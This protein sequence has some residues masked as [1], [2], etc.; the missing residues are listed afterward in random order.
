MN[1]SNNTLDLNRPVYLARRDLLLERALALF[2]EGLKAPPGRKRLEQLEGVLARLHSALESALMAAHSKRAEPR[3]ELLIAY[4]QLV[5]GYLQA[6]W[7]VLEYESQLD[8]PRGPLWKFMRR[9]DQVAPPGSARSGEA[10]LQDIARL[11]RLG[12]A[13][14]RELQQTLAGSMTPEERDR[15]RRAYEGFKAHRHAFG[16]ARRVQL[17]PNFLASS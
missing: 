16:R 12:E 14:L 1:A 9:E 6:A 3:E 10:L 5:A 7:S 2:A 13:P 8:N 11:L 17:R 4:L 15:Y